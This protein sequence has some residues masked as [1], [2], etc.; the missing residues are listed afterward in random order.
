MQI[1]TYSHYIQNWKKRKKRSASFIK[2]I[3][4]NRR[5][6]AVIDKFYLS[7]IL[8]KIESK[9]KEADHGSIK[10]NIYLMHIKQRYIWEWLNSHAVKAN[11]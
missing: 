10:K 7:L 4:Q 3:F 6:D 8:F 11:T 9:E 1:L 2:N 5:C